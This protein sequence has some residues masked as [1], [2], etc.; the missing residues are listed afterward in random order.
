MGATAGTTSTSPPTRRAA[1]IL[2]KQEGGPSKPNHPTNKKC[3]SH[4]I[5]FVHAIK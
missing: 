2:T 3:P 1:L 5:N 4:K